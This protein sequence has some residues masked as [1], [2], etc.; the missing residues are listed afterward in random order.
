MQ[1]PTL[2]KSRMLFGHDSGNIV[3]IE[4]GDFQCEACASAYKRLMEFKAKHADKVHF[5]FKHMPMDYHEM[6]YPTALFFEAIRMQS[7]SKALKFFENVYANQY[8]IR[9]ENFLLE[10]VRQVGADTARVKSDIMSGKVDRVIEE[11]MAEFGQLG[12]TGTPCFF[13][14]D[15]KILG[16]PSLEELERIV[17]EAVRTQPQ[18]S[19]N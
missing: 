19:R 16:V 9:D 18:L 17:D 10:A 12:L 3:I 2:D 8:R 4:Y 11:D 15:V 6:A 7:P 13:V 5:Y 1:R 14:N